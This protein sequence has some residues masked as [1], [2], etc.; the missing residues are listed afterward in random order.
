MPTTWSYCKHCATVVNPVETMSLDS[1]RMSF[2]K[3]L[4]SYFY[5]RRASCHLRDC[6]QP[7]QGQ[8]VRF[9]GLGDLVARVDYLGVRP[10]RIVM[11]QQLPFNPVI[12]S[13][14][15][16]RKFR[17]LNSQCSSFFVGCS[18]K[19]ASLEKVYVQAGDSLT[20]MRRLGVV[21]GDSDSPVCESS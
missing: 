6:P 15:V 16:R 18:S 17:D 20:S 8:L 10:Y 4:E 2:G 11:R 3:F 5:N 12:Y 19:L 13:E 7:A 9:F 1:W 14:N 21:I